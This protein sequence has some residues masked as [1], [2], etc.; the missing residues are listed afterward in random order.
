MFDIVQILRISPYSVQMRENTEQKISE[1]G[2]FTSVDVL[3][4]ALRNSGKQLSDLHFYWKETPTQVL[5]QLF[6]EHLWLLLLKK[7]F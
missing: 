2:H 5:Q 4:S 3:R 1:Y 6:I 7:T